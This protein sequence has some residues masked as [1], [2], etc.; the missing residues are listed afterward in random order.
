MD[1]QSK[2]HFLPKLSQLEFQ[3]KLKHTYAGHDCL[4][5]LGSFWNF[6]YLKKV[7]L[8]LSFLNVFLDILDKGKWCR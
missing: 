4:L 5:F 8:F 1:L 3:E 6:P 2:E 7:F